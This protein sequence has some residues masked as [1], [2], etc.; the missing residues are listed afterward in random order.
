MLRDESEAYGDAVPPAGVPAHFKRCNGHIHDFTLMAAHI[1]DADT[2]LREEGEP[3][4]LA[5]LA[6]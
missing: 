6:R 3:L 4:R 1:T 2:A 5:F